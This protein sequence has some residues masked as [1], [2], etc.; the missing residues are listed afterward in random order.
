[1]NI[2]GIIWSVFIWT[3]ISFS[4][5]GQKVI[6][7]TTLRIADSLHS[8]GQYRGAVKEYQRY[9]FYTRNENPEILLKLAYGLYEEGDHELAL[10]YYEQIYFLTDKP[11]IRFTCRLTEIQH[12][13]NIRQYNKALVSLFSLEPAIRELYPEVIHLYTAIS[14]F[15][16]E[17]YERS[18]SSFLQIVEGDSIAEE[19]IRELFSDPRRFH[20]PNPNTIGI[21]SLFIPGLGQMISGD[22]KEGLNS[23]ILVGGLGTGMV[24]VALRYSLLDAV[25]TLLPWYQRYLLGGS[26]K[27]EEIARYKRAE[28]RNE[29]YLEVLMVLDPYREKLK[30]PVHT[31]GD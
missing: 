14:Y 15:G 5:C 11:T 30:L 3:G 12:F 28:N 31:P 4:V 26:D 16:L 10:Q 13:I 23:L 21:L 2:T 7:E 8:A 22:F 25:L 18:L 17:D 1:M 6:P 24:I 20:K 19:K 29:V 9:L 27:A